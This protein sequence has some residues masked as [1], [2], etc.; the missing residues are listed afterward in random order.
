MKPAVNSNYT[1]TIDQLAARTWPKCN[2]VRFYNFS[3]RHKK[4]PRAAVKEK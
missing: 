1:M 2:C 3:P 4:C